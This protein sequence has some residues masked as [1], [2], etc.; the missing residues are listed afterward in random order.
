[1]KEPNRIRTSDYGSLI[2][3][4]AGTV[5]G[6]DR[7][8][9]ILTGW[10]AIEVVGRSKNLLR[11]TRG[12]ES[13]PT[14]MRTIPLYEGEVPI[15]TRP[16]TVELA[17]HCLDGRRLEVEALVSRIADRGEHVLVTLLRVLSRSAET[18]S[19][20]ALDV[21]DP[22]T[23][24][25]NR[26]AFL[27][28]LA[29]AFW[30]ASATARPL[31][32]ILA[33]VDHLRDVNDRLGRS[34]GDEVLQKLAGILRVAAQDEYRIGRLEDDDFG[35]LLP[36][37]GRGD[38]RQFAAGLR[39]TVERHRF[40]SQD[41]DQSVRV[42]LSLGAASFPADC[43]SEMDLVDRARDALNEARS[44]GRNRVWC[45]L[46]RPR[47]PLEVPVFFDGSVPV[48]VGYTRDMSP[49]GLFVQTA[50]PVDIGMRC[51]LTF[52]I[53]GRDN[54]VHVI[55]R[56]VRTV[57]PNVSPENRELRVPGMGVEF[58]RFGGTG[59]RHAIDS[60]LHGREATSLRPENGTLSL[61]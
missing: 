34:V 52:P 54:K 27:S 41:N 61:G 38:A 25:P 60:Y 5:L 59:D 4:R 33:D 10:P 18:Y 31:A 46:R 36:D 12:D 35:I 28:R 51:A 56:V 42:T 49:S 39:S 57:P 32:L 47:V 3:D 24:L 16:Q 45:Y 9:E 21:W 23:G 29:D 43:E 40:V 50:S 7:Q 11:P 2:V 30:Q 48:F 37:A 55:G 58:E 19:G 44:M 22:L 15:V 1:V 26:D 13:D 20:R 53:P 6:F 8:L 14:T 17:L